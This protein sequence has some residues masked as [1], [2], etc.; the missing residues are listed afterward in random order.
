MK[1]HVLAILTILGLAILPEFL[2]A[3][4]TCGDTLVCGGTYGM[5]IKAQSGTLGLWIR[6]QNK[7]AL[8][9]YSKSKAAILATSYASNAAR[10]YSQSFSVPAV[11]ARNNNYDA[12]KGESEDG[13]GVV[14]LS[15]G[16]SIADNGVYGWTNSNDYS[17]AG[18]KGVSSGDAPGLFGRSTGGNGVYGFSVNSYGLAVG[19]DTSLGIYCFTNKV[20]NNYGLYT[21]DNVYIGGKI[22][23]IGVVDP[24]IGERFKFDPE[25]KL[26]V[27]DVMVIEKGTSCLVRC[28]EANDTKVLGIIGPDL[29]VQNGEVMVIT[30]GNRGSQ[31]MP[32]KD[33]NIPERTIIRIKADARYGP[34][35]R[36]DLLTTSPTPG[37]AMKAEPV[38]INGIKIYRPGT[39]IGQ[40]LEAVNSGT[41]LIEVFVIKM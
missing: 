18:V 1:K 31:P 39:I 29:D 30:F 38:D 12:L 13:T 41:N 6:A 22:D 11:F 26:E 28:S 24:V 36:G 16:G 5:Y 25:E 10:F 33:G 21:P 3:Q 27:G 7:N 40:A 32:D 37:H 17:K 9:A 35:E 15:T 23:L 34:I 14:G 2:S 20:D 4:A 19:S 8:Q